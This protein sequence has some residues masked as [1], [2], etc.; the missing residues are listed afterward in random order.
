M[1][2]RDGKTRR[3]VLGFDAGCMTCSELARRIE[4][5]VGNKIEVLSLNDPF[6]A[7]WREQ[8]L[9]KDAPWVPT[10]VEVEGDAIRAWTGVR[11]GARLSHALGPLATWRVMQVL[12]EAND[13]LELVDSVTARAASG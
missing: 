2:Q 13:D 7:R 10:L 6:M 12:G 9:G 4:E 1:E 3:L 5:R 11:M 8:A